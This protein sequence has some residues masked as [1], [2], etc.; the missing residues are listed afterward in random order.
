M[1]VWIGVCVCVYLPYTLHLTYLFQ[2]FPCFLNRAPSV[3]ARRVD[4]GEVY[5]TDP[6]LLSMKLLKKV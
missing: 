1:Y 4:Q 5:Y 2:R 3:L 6:K